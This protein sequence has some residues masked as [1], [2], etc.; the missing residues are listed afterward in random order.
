MDHKSF[1]K[2]LPTY[3]KAELTRSSDTAGLIHLLGHLVLIVTLGALVAMQVAFWPVLMVPLGI[4]LVFL[5]TLQHEATHKTP[6]ANASLNDWVGRAVGLV[7][8]QPFEWFRYFHLAH[9]RHTNIPGKDPELA[10]P[11]PDCW[12]RWILHV[13]G[14]P[15]WA[16]AAQRLALNA[17][18]RATDD[19]LPDRVRPRIRTEARMMLCMYAGL[20][21]SF[22]VTDVLLWVWLVPLILGQPFLRLYLLAEHGRC[23]FVADMFLNTRTTFTNRCVRFLA[24]NMPYHAEHHAMPSVPFHK[25]P[26]L[27][28]LCGRHLKMT[29]PGYVRFTREFTAHLGQID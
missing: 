18:G 26:D 27:H 11:K 3:T 17:A 20:A 12:G 29:A 23:P 28:R 1:V 4:A 16:A 9:H 2:S 15:A 7:I 8:F 14:L 22:L 10:G 19:Y 25:L 13:S 5:F 21:S 24:W 6:F